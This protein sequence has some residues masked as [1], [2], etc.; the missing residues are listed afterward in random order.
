MLHNGTTN[1]RNL[2]AQFF[3]GSI[4]LALPLHREDTLGP[5]AQNRAAIPQ[6]QRNESSSSST[7]T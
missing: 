3:L 6:A 4:A 5:E 1:C 2:A 7:T